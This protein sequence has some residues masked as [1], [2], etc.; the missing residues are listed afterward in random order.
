M[1][2][3]MQQFHES[4]EQQTATIRYDAE[5]M[6]KVI[7]TATRLQQAHRETVSAEQIE[8]I[9]KEVGLDPVFV[10]RA[11][12]LVSSGSGAET[13]AATTA[14]VTPA[15]TRNASVAR[16]RER[17]RMEPLS[18]MDILGAQAPGLLYAVYA[19]I[20][21]SSFGNWRNDAGVV[22]GIVQPLLL[23]LALAARMRSR[24][25]AAILGATLG[26]CGCLAAMLGG[27]FGNTDFGSFF[28]AVFFGVFLAMLSVGTSSLSGWVRRLR[29]AAA[30]AAAA[31][32]NA[33]TP[34]T[35]ATAA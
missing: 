21:V 35:P 18:G 1:A 4:E 10:R 5:T 31:E 26:F 12:D 9:G 11:L 23:T 13:Q 8:E 7:E 27:G 2:A 6:Q 29:R 34:S 32:E 19:V 28:G 24:R 16:R 22:F 20:A 15:I 30:L 14:A 33:P 25:R 3:G 17:R